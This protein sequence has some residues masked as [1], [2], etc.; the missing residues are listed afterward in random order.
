MPN[1]HMLLLVL[2][3]SARMAG[4][5]YLV[6]TSGSDDGDG[7]ARK[8]FATVAAAMAASNGDGAATIRIGAGTFVLGAE[9]VRLRAGMSLLGAGRGTTTLVG[10]VVAGQST[11]A[12]LAQFRI[13]GFNLRGTTLDDPLQRPARGL[14]LINVQDVV[15]SD[16][17]I[18]R[19][20]QCGLRLRRAIRAT[21][22]DCV[23]TR[24]SFN[25]YHPDNPFPD[26]D[27][28]FD[29]QH[30]EVGGSEGSAIW[31][32]DCQDVVLCHLDIDTREFGGRGI[33]NSHS[34]SPD[35]DF[36]FTPNAFE[37]LEI[38]HCTIMVDQWHGWHTGSGHHP[39][40][41]TVEFS[42]WRGRE[43]RI[44]H[45]LY[46]QG[47]SM[48][49]YTDPAAFTAPSLRIDHNRF[50]LIQT[51]PTI[52]SYVLET[53]VPNLEF[54]HNHVV[55]G[56]TSI[57]NFAGSGTSVP[58]MHIHH[59]VWE[60]LSYKALLQIGS[61]AP[62]L[63]FV[64][65]IVYFTTQ[66]SGTVPVSIA[67]DNG[68]SGAPIAQGP[69]QIVANN[70][71]LSSS[72]ANSGL[73]MGFST[74]VHHNRFWRLLNIGSEATS[75][76][77]LLVGNGIKPSEWFRLSATSPAIDAG[78]PID[79]FSADTIGAPDLGAFEHGRSTWF[80][81]PNRP[82]SISGLPAEVTVAVGGTVTL[83]A[84]VT[85]DGA[86]LGGSLGLSGSAPDDAAATINDGTTARA[87]LT[88]PK[89]GTWT[90]RLCADDGDAQTEARIQV[91]VGSGVTPP[92]VSTSN[93]DDG[94]GRHCGFG[95]A[96]SLLAFLAIGFRLRSQVRR[97]A[98][99][100][101]PV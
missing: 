67:G 82:P 57:A 10:R 84:T 74:G 32:G 91:V 50:A 14:D 25:P 92:A 79:P 47:F 8:P 31:L 5:D 73:R 56:T 6:S 52:Y 26:A 22:T 55:N 51:G 38:G 39:P 69:D 93:D 66:Q 85:D 70:L 13:G 48:V 54:D 43:V 78:T 61:R 83:A 72:S 27:N 29:I 76:D 87:T 101:M 41:F 23:L 58:G 9:P 21:V 97:Y 36:D 44:H 75:G 77:P 64:H 53:T 2:G 100:R 68:A 30:P 20:K 89:E 96:V 59:N 46:N 65:N 35:G 24:C 7:S 12:T 34:P 42:G 98:A 1:M 15:I 88:F 95:S 45:G 28:T 4:A 99:E 90:I 18:Q 11:G 40:Q 37:R 16:V 86:P 62:G 80:V 94:G 17:D 3:L 60:G 81:G 63:A 49:P 33:G 71:F 19:Y